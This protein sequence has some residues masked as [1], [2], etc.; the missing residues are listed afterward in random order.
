MID[1]FLF[2]VIFIVVAT[3]LWHFFPFAAERKIRSNWQVP[4]PVIA[5]VAVVQ[6]EV[7]PVIENCSEITASPL[8]VRHLT[9]KATLLVRHRARKQACTAHLIVWSGAKRKRVSDSYYD[10]GVIQSVGTN[11][12]VIDEF[13]AIAKERLDE[14]ATAG[15][16]KRRIEQA[17][18]QEDVVKVVATVTG[19]VPIETIPVVSAQ[20]VVQPSVVMEDTPPESTKLKKFPS[21]YRGVITEVGMMPQSKDGKEFTTYGLRYRTPEGVE[22]AVYGVNLRNAL[23]DAM[24]NVGDHVEILKIGRR[25]VEQGKAPMNLFKVAKLKAV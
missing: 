1:K 5:P 3:V 14:L 7:I 12:E 10:L 24:A 23:R 25:T 21:V 18:E 13:L 2:L 8:I 4:T 20:V 15:R 9:N 16:R 6:E 11:D 17:S 19:S 22:D